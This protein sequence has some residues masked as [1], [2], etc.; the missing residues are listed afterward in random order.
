M[1]P[2]TF[3]RLIVFPL[4]CLGLCHAAF[5]ID[6]I[7]PIQGVGVSGTIKSM[8][9]DKVVITVRNRDQEFAVAEIKRVEL[10]GEPS[11]LTQAKEFVLSGQYSQAL[12]SLKRVDQKQVSE[13]PTVKNEFL[14]YTFYTRSNLALEGGDDARAMANELNRFANP[15]SYHY[16]EIQEMLGRLALSIDQP[17]TANRFFQNL[18]SAADKSTQVRGRYWEGQA[19]LQQNDTATAKQ[20]FQDILSITPDSPPLY[21][22]HALAKIGLAAVTLAND[23][24]TTSIDTL[25]DLIRETDAK[26]I[27]LHAKIQ[28]LKGAAYARLGNDEAALLSYLHIDLLASNL[29]AEHAEALYHLGQLWEKVGQVSKADAAK[30]QLREKYPRSSWNQ[31]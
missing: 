24:A 28:L 14:Y 3:N 16:Y 20:A 6:R 11:E 4:F 19:A 30:T 1:R 18:K 25:N 23:D 29:P 31:K 13:S 9:K 8:D 26:N 17:D 2:S 5:G 10:D 7:F 15:Q 27:E 21:E 12:D 22:A